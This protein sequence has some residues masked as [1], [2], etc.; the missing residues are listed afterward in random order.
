MKYIYEYILIY[1]TDVTWRI[2]DAQV[3]AR[4]PGGA[5]PSI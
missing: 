3:S 2:G 4:S 1:V 5:L